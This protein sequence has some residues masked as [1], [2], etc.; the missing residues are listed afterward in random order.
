MKKGTLKECSLRQLAALDERLQLLEQEKTDIKE[1]AREAFA[2][3]RENLQLLKQQVAAYTFSG[4]AEEIDF[5]RHIKPLFSAKLIYYYRLFHFYAAMPRWGR[6]QRK[7]HF[8]KELKTIQLF[9]ADHHYFCIYYNAGSTYLDD[10]YFVRGHDDISLLPADAMLLYDDTFSASHDAIVAIILAYDQL[11]EHLLDALR[12]RKKRWLT[13]G[14][15]MSWTG[16]KAALIELI[17]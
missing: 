16:Y 2:L 1:L 9:F 6:R 13:L 12:S 4:P 3:C 15:A 14:H 5:F 7:A 17:Y 8:K 11:E 10:Q